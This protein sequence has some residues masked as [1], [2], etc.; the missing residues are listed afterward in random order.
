MWF[1][2]TQWLKK[3]WYHELKVEALYRSSRPE[4]FCKK[5]VLKIYV[6]FTGKHLCQSPFLTNLQASVCNFI[7]TE[8]LTQVFSCEFYKILK[9]TF[10]R[11]PPVAASDVTKTLCYLLW[12]HLNPKITIWF[13][14]K[15]IKFLSIF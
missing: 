11:T 8:I 9:S 12:Y 14:W 1:D 10:Y 13:L 5:G 2:M 7:K 15:Q 4:V 3:M 6:K